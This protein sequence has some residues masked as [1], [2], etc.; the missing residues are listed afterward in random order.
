MGLRTNTLTPCTPYLRAVFSLEVARKQSK[1]G[2]R[3]FLPFSN[4]QRYDACFPVGLARPD[5]MCRTSS[6]GGA[7]GIECQR[8][9]LAFQIEVSGFIGRALH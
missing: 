8:V 5:S 3:D 7:N 4:S 6:D 2:D 1:R 9:T